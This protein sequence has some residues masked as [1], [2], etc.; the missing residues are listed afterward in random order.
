MGV[1]CRTLIASVWRS[2]GV[3]S[4]Q[5]LHLVSWVGWPCIRP[6]RHFRAGM[7]FELE[8]SQS[9][10]QTLHVVMHRQKKL[11]SLNT[12]TFAGRTPCTDLQCTEKDSH[13][14]QY[15]NPCR[16]TW[17]ALFGSIQGSPECSRRETACCCFHY[18]LLQWQWNAFKF[19]PA[20]LGAKKFVFS[21]SVSSG[22][23]TACLIQY[24]VCNSMQVK[25]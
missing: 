20:T 1:E 13:T 12:G 14:H 6:G 23:C 5:P 7:K 9:T 18:S 4:K 15:D 2:P 8:A 21:K 10:Q 24:I 25:S 22:F 11:H 3:C 19:L 17:D 16:P